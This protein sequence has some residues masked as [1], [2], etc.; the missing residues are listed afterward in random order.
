MSVLGLTILLSMLSMVGPLGIDAYLP[1]FHAISEEFGAGPLVVQQ[2]LSVYTACLAVMMLFYGTLSDSFGRRPVILVGLVLF[3]IGSVAAALAPSVGW[4]ILARAFEGLAAGAGS[5]VGRAVVQDRFQGP[6]AHRVMSHMTMF[7]GLAPAIA[8]VIGGILQAFYGWRS[9]FWFLALATVALTLA[10]Y[11]GLPESL[12]VEKRQPFHFGKIARNYWKVMR[13]PRFLFM[14][15]ATG[16]AFSGISIYVA[17]ASNFV[18]KIL[19]LSETSFAWMFIP[20][21]IGLMTGSAFAPKLLARTS[22]A[23]VIKVGFGVMLAA[24]LAS[25]A[26]THLF[27]AAVPWAVLPL[28]IYAFGIALASPGMTLQILSIFPEIRGMAA[29]IQ[30]FVQMFTFALVSGLLAPLLFDSAALIALGHLGG[31]LVSLCLWTFATRKQKV[32]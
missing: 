9:V 13:H 16:T 22:P 10:V 23:T 8:P 6:A 11:R 15:L 26:Y 31:V 3:V 32:A 24:A 20:M 19:G 1:S 2:T 30:A 21:V 18:M 7:F 25:V 28:G 14:A 27:V 12:P 4:L 29:S 5:V 17:S